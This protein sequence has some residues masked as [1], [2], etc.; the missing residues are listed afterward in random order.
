MKNNASEKSQE[1]TWN[2]TDRDGH[3]YGSDSS[4]R[5]RGTCVQGALANTSRVMGQR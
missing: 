5:V 1:R 2:G 3:P 4:L